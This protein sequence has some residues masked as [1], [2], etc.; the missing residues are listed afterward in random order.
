MTA[1][2]HSSDL[3]FVVRA[4]EVQFISDTFVRFAGVTTVLTV[5]LLIVLAAVRTNVEP[6]KKYVRT[7]ARSTNPE[8]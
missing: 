6:V 7:R 1:C 3:S 5:V 4:A 8:I 2:C